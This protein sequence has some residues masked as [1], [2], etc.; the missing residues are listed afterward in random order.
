MYIVHTRSRAFRDFD[1][2]GCKIQVFFE[3]INFDSSR[4]I[5]YRRNS[6]FY[7]SASWSLIKLGYALPK[8]S[9][10]RACLG[11]LNGTSQQSWRE[12]KYQGSIERAWVAIITRRGFDAARFNDPYL[13][14]NR[15]FIYHKSNNSI[16]T[17]TNSNH[18]LKS[19]FSIMLGSVSSL[20]R[21]SFTNSN[22]IIP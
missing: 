16:F 8:T 12:S 15:A 13:K 9:S 2:S 1:R 20:T 7:H 6:I 3:K 14:L 22:I 21:C 4:K 18:H 11:W 19:L 10:P 5:K 17:V